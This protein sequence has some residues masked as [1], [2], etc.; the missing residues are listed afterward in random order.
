MKK[1]IIYIILLIVLVIGIILF[2]STQVWSKRENTQ[3]NTN[4]LNS[5]ISS[6]KA[7][8]ENEVEEE[9][10]KIIKTVKTEL[11]DG[12]LYSVS[13]EEIKSDVILG[14]NYFDTQINDININPETYKGKNIEIEGMYL[15][16]SPYT[17]V[18][19][20]STSNLCQYCPT[21]YSYMEY[22]WDGEKIELEDEVSWIKVVGTLEKMNDETTY[23]QDYYYIKAQTIEVMKESGLKTVNN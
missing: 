11:E 5:S 4:D 12:T 14:D 19:R 3:N 15:T 20:Y 22:T 23:Y 13:N 21:G 2:F 8:K 17:F 10:K 9:N 1:K 7:T 16:N 18:G 6:Q